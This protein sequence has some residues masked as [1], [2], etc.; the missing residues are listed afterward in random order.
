MI[1]ILHRGK[2]SNVC[3]HLVFAIPVSYDLTSYLCKLLVRLVR[4]RFSA[5]LL[6]NQRHRSWVPLLE[7]P[8]NFPGPKAIFSSSKNGEAYTPKTSCMKRTSDCVKNTW[9]KQLCDHM[10]FTIL[11]WPAFRRRKLF[12]TPEKRAPVLKSYISLPDYVSAH[13]NPS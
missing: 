2:W 3:F 12:G 5:L 9:I 13:R 7:S 6:S 1:C 11:L 4:H 10:R 8:G